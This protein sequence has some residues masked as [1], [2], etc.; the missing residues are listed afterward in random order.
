MKYFVCINA[1]IE[2]TW[3]CYHLDGQIKRGF[4]RKR[5]GGGG[6]CKKRTVFFG[7]KNTPLTH[8]P[9]LTRK[10]RIV[11]NPSMKPDSRCAVA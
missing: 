5:G 6:G 2:V 4:S 8:V 1:D 10:Y 7:T 11:H 3:Y 9:S